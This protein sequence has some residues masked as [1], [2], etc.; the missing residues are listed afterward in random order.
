MRWSTGAFASA[1]CGESGGLLTLPKNFL[2]PEEGWVPTFPKARPNPPRG[3][4]LT[5]AVRGTRQGLTRK[6][7]GR[8]SRHEL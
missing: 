4:P 1:Q 2:G 5:R 6:T 8:R 3:P 7:F